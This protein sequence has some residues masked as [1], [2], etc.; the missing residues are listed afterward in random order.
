MAARA[1]HS[2]KIVTFDSRAHF[3]MSIEVPLLKVLSF[4]S[5]G[6]DKISAANPT[7]QF[8]HKILG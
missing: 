8:L 1:R 6:C 4:A 3:E 5:S 2:Q 7:A